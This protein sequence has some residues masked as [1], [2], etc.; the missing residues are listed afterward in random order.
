M[1]WIVIKRA[2]KEKCPPGITGVWDT[3]KVPPKLWK[4]YERTELPDGTTPDIYVDPMDG[5]IEE[6]SKNYPSY[7]WKWI[8][9]SDGVKTGSK[10]E[11]LTAADEGDSTKPED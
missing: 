4:E 11:D 7:F 1:R 10:D 6:L 8:T 9:I 2:R 3:Y 5:Y